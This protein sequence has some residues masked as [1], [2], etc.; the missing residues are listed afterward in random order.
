MSV[1]SKKSALSSW[2][3]E[4]VANGQRWVQAWRD[5]SPVLEAI[6]KRELR[7]LDSERALELLCGPADYT[8]PPRAPKP[9]IGPYRAAT[10]VYEGQ[11]L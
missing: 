2:T 3:P 11:T 10:L 1:N 8:V 4:Q 9:H 6:R 5:A 7:E